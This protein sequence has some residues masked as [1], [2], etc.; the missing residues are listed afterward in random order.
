[1]VRT[2]KYKYNDNGLDHIITTEVLSRQS[3]EAYAGIFSH[4][5]AGSIT[6]ILI[7]RLS[8]SAILMERSKTLIGN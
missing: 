1:M 7:L 6:K 8:F 5:N 4:N 3:T 2:Q